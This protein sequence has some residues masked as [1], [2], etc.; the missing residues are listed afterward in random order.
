MTKANL[1]TNLRIQ[2]KKRVGLDG[3]A[4]HIVV[5]GSLGAGAVY[6]CKR[7]RPDWGIS[8]SEYSYLIG[9]GASIAASMLISLL[10][11]D[12]DQRY[13][14]MKET[15]TAQL[16]SNSDL[17]AKYP[18]RFEAGGSFSLAMAAAC[19]EGFKEALKQ[20]KEE[21]SQPEAKGAKK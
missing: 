18:D 12:E 19:E 4:F 9:M 20:E 5:G 15:M 10:A 7:Y 8:Q 2:T 11:M 21:Q 1:Y 3:A 17:V 6:A 14:L 16:E 13:L